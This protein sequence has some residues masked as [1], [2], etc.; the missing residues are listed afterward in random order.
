MIIV[1]AES[2]ARP[3]NITQLAVSASHLFVNDYRTRDVSPRACAMGPFLCKTRLASLLKTFR[4]AY[5]TT[6]GRMWMV[7][8]EGGILE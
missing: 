2:R 5:V 8:G 6:G 1:L 7:G 4:L 3:L